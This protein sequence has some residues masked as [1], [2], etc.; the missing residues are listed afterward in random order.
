MCWAGPA[1]T[2]WLI[3]FS[4]AHRAQVCKE[5]TAEKGKKKWFTGTSEG[6]RK[7]KK[8]V[9]ILPNRNKLWNSCPTLCTAREHGPKGSALPEGNIEILTTRD[10]P[11][12]PRWL[13]AGS[14]LCPL[15]GPP[16]ELQTEQ[17]VPGAGRLSLLTAPRKGPTEPENSPGWVME[18]QSKPVYPTRIISAKK[19]KELKLATGLDL[20]PTETFPFMHKWLVTA[21]GAW[22]LCWLFIIPV[23]AVHW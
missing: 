22:N 3:H 16:A 15:P 18:S 23:T 12:L 10:N 19:K 4:A 17:F 6:Q 13:P 20:S 8:K 11:L 14:L 7:K 9:L 1:S 5:K 21:A 2:L